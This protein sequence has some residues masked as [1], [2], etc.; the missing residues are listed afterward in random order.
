MTTYSGFSTF[1]RTRKFKVTD[2]DLVKQDLINHFYIRKGEKL[3]NPN[4]GSIIWNLLFDPFTPSVKDTIITDIKTIVNYDP[5]LSV[6]EL[7]VTEYQYGIQIILN[8]R[9]VITNQL[10]VMTLNFDRDSK[11]LSVIN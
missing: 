10:A 11:R 1:N 6:D 3:M 8:L 5:R 4:F 2:F 7:S 9:Y